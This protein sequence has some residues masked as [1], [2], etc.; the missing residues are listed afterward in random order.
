[1]ELVDAVLAGRKSLAIVMAEGRNPVRPSEWLT[2]KI[3]RKSK[4]ADDS[5]GFA[6]RTKLAR[7][8]AI[9]DNQTWIGDR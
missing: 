2:L 7:D 3:I 5:I 1:M 9:E 4:H 6:E 8:Q